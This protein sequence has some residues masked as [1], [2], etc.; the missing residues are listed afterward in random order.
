[1]QTFLDLAPMLQVLWCIT[2][3]SSGLFAGLLIRAFRKPAVISTAS[4]LFSSRNAVNFALGFGWTSVSIYG[5]LAS[6]TAVVFISLCVAIA[7]A[8]IFFIMMRNLARQAQNN[9]R[10]ND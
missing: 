5:E 7:F 4:R 10:R 2:I 8:V 1:M 9:H 3:A 6:K